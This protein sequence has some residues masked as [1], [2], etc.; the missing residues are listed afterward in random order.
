MH[1]YSV[2]SSFFFFFFMLFLYMCAFR[3][4]KKI[5]LCPYT[6]IF[7]LKSYFLSIHLSMYV[8]WLWQTIGTV[9][10]RKSDVFKILTNIKVSSETYLMLWRDFSNA[11]QTCIVVPDTNNWQ[12][13]TPQLDGAIVTIMFSFRD[14]SMARY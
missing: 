4:F 3:V 1:F 13:Q 8:S 7:Y 9:L 2:T 11:G 14:S 10:K 6:L 5:V 12:I